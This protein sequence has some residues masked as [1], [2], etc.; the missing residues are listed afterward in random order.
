MRKSFTILTAIFLCLTQQAFAD[1]SMDPT[2][3]KS[4]GSSSTFTTDDMSSK[5]CAH[6]AKACIGAGYVRR[7][8]NRTFWRGC[9]RPLLL[10]Q[11][12]T[13]VNVN[14]QDVMACRNFKIKKMQEELKNL[15]QVSPA[16]TQ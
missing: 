14:S 12:V 6:I 8:A 1:V 2:M 7:G 5:E 11:R 4:A 16:Q 9:M 15:Q 3:Q 13:G 10:G